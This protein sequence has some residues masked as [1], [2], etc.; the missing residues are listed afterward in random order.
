M[1]RLRKTF[2]DT[3]G[4]VRRKQGAGFTYLD[5]GRRLTADER[6]RC[7]ALAIP[8]A[9]TDVWIS[10]VSNGHI[11]AVGTDDRGR[12]Q[13][14]Y[15]EAW[16]ERRDR[17]KYEALVDFAERL[18]QARRT[19]RRHLQKEE[20]TAQK[21]SALAFRMLDVGAFRIGGRRYAEDNGSH[22]LL[23]LTWDHIDLTGDVV[24]FTF[25]AKSG[26]LREFDSDDALTR[27]TLRA[28]KKQ[29][30]TEQE[31]LTY[32]D[33]EDWSRLADEQLSAYVKKRL[34]ENATAKQFRT[35]RANVVAA[36]VLALGES[37]TKREQDR[38][39]REA[40]D[41]AA[42]HLG[43]T[44]A[45]TKSSYVDPRLIEQ[46]REGLTIDPKVARRNF[47]VLGRQL[48]QRLELST[49]DLLG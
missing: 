33:G 45:I 30:P 8:P 41:A 38:T 31:V 40:L 17:E 11:Q 6:A 14:I 48:S 34:C 29:H 46:F 43:N 10:P 36:A 37:S 19:V 28:L 24:A 47:P 1:T 42:D 12:R 13:Y 25:L 20:M 22:G 44:P 39:V 32:W 3:P 2:P 49:M 18:P 23:T 7:E 27:N 21:I 16:R 35:W 15:H 9:W 4:W 5:G 26:Q